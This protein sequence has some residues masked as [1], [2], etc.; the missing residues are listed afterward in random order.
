MMKTKTY[1]VSEARQHWAEI[2]D[3]V[4]RGEEVDITK[5]G[6]LVAIITS[7]CKRKQKA[8]PPPGFLAAEGWKV[9][10]ADDFDAIPEGFE[11]YV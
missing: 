6:S 7:S 9:E 8:A 5:F 1:S 11:D 2:I 10:M 4:E 3:A